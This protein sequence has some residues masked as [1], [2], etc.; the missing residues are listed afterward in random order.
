MTLPN[1]SAGEGG[2]WGKCLVPEWQKRRL[3]GNGHCTG[4]MLRAAK[5]S[6]SNERMHTP[7]RQP[8]TVR[9]RRKQTP[10]PPKPDNLPEALFRNTSFITP[11]TS[12][13]RQPP[14][15]PAPSSGMGFS[16]A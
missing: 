9:T 11:R 15:P 6:A 8:Q 14:P 3:R 10:V 16:H 13:S 2:G 4:C 5:E 7:L 12:G 1:T